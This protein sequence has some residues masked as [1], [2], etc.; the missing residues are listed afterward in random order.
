MLDIKDLSV[1]F[2]NLI[3]VNTLNMNVSENTIHSLIGPNGAGKTT[4]FNAIYNFVPYTGDILFKEKSLKHVPTHGLSQMG[5]SRTFQNLSLFYSMTVEHNIALGLHPT[6]KSNIFKDISG[7]NIYS[8]KGIKEKI[9]SVAELVGLTQ[10][11][12]AY[13]L[14]LPYGTQK[15]VELARALV[16][17]PQ[18]LLLDEPA[19]GLNS[20]EKD[21]FKKILLE[22]KKRGIT[23]LL[24]EHDMGV[25]MDIS[26]LITVMNFGEKIAEGTPEEVS[27]NPEVIQAYLGVE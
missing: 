11:L 3:A 1:H 27:E 14:F 2:G 8:Q 9:K 15:L 13:P 12:N 7:V 19:A 18:L 17:D 5:I 24:V 25:V 4:V 26:D 10:L 6:A 23:I 21:Y 22:V 16:N 20:A